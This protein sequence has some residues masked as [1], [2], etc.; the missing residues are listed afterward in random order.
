MGFT[1]RFDYILSEWVVNYW[2]DGKTFLTGKGSTLS[3]ALESLKSEAC[4]QQ[5]LIW[6]DG[7]VESS[8]NRIAK[9]RKM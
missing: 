3:A 9:R 5:I 8:F 6:L 7:S 2:E 4:E 1:I